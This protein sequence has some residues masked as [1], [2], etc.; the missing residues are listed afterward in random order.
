MPI[1]DAVRRLRTATARRE[2]TERRAKNARLGED[3][4]LSV[5]VPA[6]EVALSLHTTLRH[7]ADQTF[8]RYEVIVVDDGSPDD[9]AGTVRAA[10]VEDPRVTLVRQAN[11]GPSAARNTGIR[12]ARAPYLTFVDG[13]DTLPPRAWEHMMSTLH[14]TGSD[15][16]VGAL[17]RTDGD[18]SWK[19]ERM[20]R[21]HAVRR[22]RI[23]VAQMPEILADVFPVNKI[24]RRDFWDRLGLEFPEGLFYEDQ[25]VL[26]RAFLAGT[27]DV[28]PETVYEYYVRPD[29]SSTTQ[30]RHTQRDLEDRMTTK[31]MT[32]ASVLEH[33]DPV[34]TRTF[35]ADVLPVD[36]WEYFRSVPNC[37]QTY[38][39]LLVQGTRELWNADTVPFEETLVPVQQRLM[40]WFVVHGRRAELEQLFA[41][42]DAEGLPRV[43]VDGVLLLD[44]PWRLEPG[45]PPG[46][47]RV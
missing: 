35:F 21:N 7:I 37:S 17:E 5:V 6:Y 42:I 15:F 12:L 26:T 24:Y 28:I 44:H 39:D 36:M 4:L 30:N 43:E 10:A 41:F 38:W 40:G 14:R 27:F 3:P 16:C 13:D 32:V 23:R 2:A 19:T 25:P 31:Q 11:A 18:R 34:V 29:K 46:C 8:E 22:E 45:L 9:V 1:L 47:V 33:G 20:A